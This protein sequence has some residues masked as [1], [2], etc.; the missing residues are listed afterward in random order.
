MTWKPLAP[1]FAAVLIFGGLCPA[2]AE[3]ETD[4]LLDTIAGY[5]DD[6]EDTFDDAVDPS[7]ADDADD[8][9]AA[10]DRRRGHGPDSRHWGR[11]GPG[12]R[13]GPPP[14]RGYGMH[15]GYGMPRG[16][17]WD[18]GPGFGGPRHGGYG[19]RRPGL[20]R[21]ARMF[22]PREFDALKLTADQKKQ[23]ADILTESYR[24]RLEAT[25]ELMEARQKLREV[26]RKDPYDADAVIAA[27]TAVGSARGKLDV[28]DRQFR[29]KLKALLTADQQKALDDLRTPPG[30]RPGDRKPG[31]RGDRRP[32]R[33]PDGPG[34]R[35]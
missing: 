32:P 19:H 10:F 9:P 3:D 11:R 4:S 21:A 25:M 27:N 28:I 33:G 1:L 35:R 5:E 12:W 34:P 20:G 13:Q 24:A 7:E 23:V 8:D 17:G 18:K 26:S 14:P 22:G 2:W 6:L 29:D 16:Y 30:R 15:H 31:D